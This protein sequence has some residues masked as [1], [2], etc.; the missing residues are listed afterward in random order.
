MSHLTAAQRGNIETLLQEKYTNKDIAKKI[1][2]NPSTISREILRGLDGAGIYRPFV[3]QV[4]YSTNR[5]RSKQIP[6]LDHPANYRLRS[7]VVACIERGW[8]PAQTAGRLRKDPEWQDLP[9]FVCA[10]T[11]YHWG[12]YQCLCH[13]PEAIPVSALRQETTY[14]TQGTLSSDVQDTQP[15]IHPRPASG[16]GCSYPCR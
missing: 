4:V 16:R 3:A 15:G 9:V 1:G 11:I 5:K 14:Q 12:L 2:K 10:E 13:C 7:A 8:D 6:I